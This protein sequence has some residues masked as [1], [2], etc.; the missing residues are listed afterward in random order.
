MYIGVYFAWKVVGSNLTQGSEFFSAK[1]AVLGELCWFALS[2]KGRCGLDLGQSH[3][4][5]LI[6]GYSQVRRCQRCRR[7]ELT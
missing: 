4:F 5:H 1:I 6:T 3:F 2:V 7:E